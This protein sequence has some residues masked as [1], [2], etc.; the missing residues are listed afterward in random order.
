M[1][2]FLAFQLLV[3]N[4]SFIGYDILTRN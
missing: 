2:I 4:Q 3:V 1:H